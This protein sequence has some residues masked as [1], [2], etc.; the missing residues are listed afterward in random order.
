MSQCPSCG[1]DCGYGPLRHCQQ[2]INHE[3]DF[4]ANVC[5]SDE[6]LANA[7]QST[8][9]LA[10]KI[11]GQQFRG[12][13][14]QF[15]SEDEAEIRAREIEELKS[16]RNRLEGEL[17]KANAQTE[18][19]ERKW[20]LCCDQIEEQQE[21]ITRREAVIKI[22]EKD[23]DLATQTV[24]FSNGA[25]VVMLNLMREALQVIETIEGDDSDEEAEL[26][27]LKGHMSKLI[28]QSISSLIG[29]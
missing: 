29:K 21:V 13:G 23:L 26:N 11:K 17:K 20:Y 5:T 22:L 15:R 1:G 8:R 16:E 14:N 7:T 19:F 18:E 27:R 6:W 10:N 12:T 2:G 4:R 24:H 25:Q 9:D 3:T 28:D